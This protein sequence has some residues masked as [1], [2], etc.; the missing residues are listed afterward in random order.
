[1]SKDNT[2]LKLEVHDFGN[3]EAGFYMPSY[4]IEFN[5]RAGIKKVVPSC[6]QCVS[7]N[8][9]DKRGVSVAV[10]FSGAKGQTFEKQVTIHWDD[11]SF[12]VAHLKA[13][14]T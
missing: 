8:Q 3:V 9:Y 2:K 11:D 5:S 6:G 4:F 1:M 7:V 13:T 12:S 10:M 14:L